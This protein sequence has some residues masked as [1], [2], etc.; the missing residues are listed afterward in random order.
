MHSGMT[1]SKRSAHRYLEKKT[2]KTGF[3]Q[4]GLS[5]PLGATVYPGDEKGKKLHSFPFR[6]V[7]RSARTMSA[8][9]SP[10]AGSPEDFR[11]L[12]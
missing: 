1:N 10:V 5:A 8:A 4:K 2:M 9:R 12:F 3:V 11:L 7:A 6:K